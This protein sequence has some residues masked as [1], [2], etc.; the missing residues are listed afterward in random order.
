MAI[1]NIGATGTNDGTLI[2]AA[3]ATAGTGGS[4][5]VTINVEG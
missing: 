5:G 4:Y 1:V 3:I 2:N